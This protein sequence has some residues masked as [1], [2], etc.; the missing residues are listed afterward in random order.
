MD[1][2][3]PLCLSVQITFQF[4]ATF[5]TL[6]PLVDCSSAPSQHGDLT[7]VPTHLEEII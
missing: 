1:L 3:P 5:T 2:F 6:V 4:I 7:E